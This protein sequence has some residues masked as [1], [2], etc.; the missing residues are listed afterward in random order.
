MVLVFGVLELKI[1]ISN[2]SSGRGQL[3]LYGN[4]KEQ[5]RTWYR[6]DAFQVVRNLQH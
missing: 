1:V 5:F 3:H 4:M 2:V 6:D